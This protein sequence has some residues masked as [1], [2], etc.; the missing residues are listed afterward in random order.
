MFI[1][2]PRTVEMMTRIPNEIHAPTLIN[3]VEKGKTP[4]LNN[5]EL[6]K[7]GF[8]IAIYANAPMKA[9]IKGTQLLLEYLKREGTTDGCDDELMIPTS[10]S[11]TTCRKNT[12]SFQRLTKEGYLCPRKNST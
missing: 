5:R 2:A 8:K 4:L 3:L 1:E 10:N 12:N 11:I 7:L 6:E 9:A